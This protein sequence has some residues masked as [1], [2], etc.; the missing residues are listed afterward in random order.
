MTN[1][2]LAAWLADNGKPSVWN[3]LRGF[4]E[5]LRDPDPEPALEGALSNLTVPELHEY[6]AYLRARLAAA[7]RELEEAEYCLH[8]YNEYTMLCQFCRMIELGREWLAR[9]RAAREAG[10]L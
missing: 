2:D 10:A 7:E 5:G 8:M 4:M 9:R 6:V 3:Q 1:D